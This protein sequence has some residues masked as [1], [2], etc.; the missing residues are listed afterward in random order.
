MPSS[1]AEFSSDGPWLKK[2]PRSKA[3]HVRMPPG[4]NWHAGSRF[5]SYEI[6]AAIGTGGMGEVYRARDPKLNRDVAIK[7]LLPSVIADPN[8]IAR[9]RREAQVLA[10]LN[11]PNIA[12]IHGIEEDGGITALI[13]ELVEGEDLSQRI[14]RGPLPIDEALAIARQIAEA[15]EA[16]HDLGIIHRDLK[17]ANIK[18]RADGTVKVLDFGLAKASDPTAS[19]SADLM[20]SPTLSIHATQAGIILGTA[21]YMSPEQARGK[22]VDRRT[23]IWALGCVLFEMLTGN[24]P[25]AG[26]DATDTLVAVMSKEPRWTTLPASVPDAVRALLHLTL[27]KQPRDRLDSAA[28]FRLAIGEPLAALGSE[29][30]RAPHV[31]SRSQRLAVLAW[32][33]A[34]SF[35]IALL[36]STAYRSQ[37]SSANEVIRFAIEPASYIRDLNPSPGYSLAASPDGTKL[38]FIAL[39]GNVLRIYVR[40][41]RSEAVTQVAGTEGGYLPFWSPDGRRLGFF[42]GD[43]LYKLDLADGR[44]ILVSEARSPLGGTWNANQDILFA[45]YSGFYRVAADNGKAVKVEVKDPFSRAERGF[46]QFLPDNDHFLY[47]AGGPFDS[48]AIFV[49]SLT[50]PESKLVSNADSAG[51]YSA[52][53]FLLFTKGTAL[54][55]QSFDL[56]SLLTIGQPSRLVPDIASA[57]N[58][59][60]LGQGVPTFAVSGNLLAFVPAVGNASQQTWFARN[61][62]QLSVLPLPASGEFANPAISPDGLQVLF[63]RID[64]ETGN[65]DVWLIRSDGTS[66]TRLTFDAAEESDAVWSPDGRSI[67]FLSTRNQKYGLYRKSV[68]SQD[69]DELIKEFDGPVLPSSWS[70]DG[71]FIVYSTLESTPDVWALP[72]DGDRVPVPVR[73]SAFSEYGAQ[74]SP[75]SRW[76]AYASD[77]TGASEVYVQ[78]FPQGGARVRVSNSGGG[79][80]PRWRSDGK[81]LFY[82]HLTSKRVFAIG[83]RSDGT[84]VTAGPER[85]MLD[86]TLDGMSDARN[87]YAVAPDGQ[88]ALLRKSSVTARQPSISV[89]VNWATE[90]RHAGR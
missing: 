76:I 38:A 12:H 3:T 77:E 86:V 13:L 63:N 67:A 46:P 15:L 89:M 21:A 79:I 62:T 84:T 36:V 19:L 85:P 7:V 20:N 90:L 22:S 17:P 10:S 60:E 30:Y 45:S 64:P 72:L 26:E 59:A 6:V 27:Q 25:F 69:D 70:P 11:H 24:R 65:R 56:K 41:L 53:G 14:G 49:G 57:W 58:S 78:A 29:H 54:M 31:W 33:L 82:W 44:P 73:R 71:R 35:A 5:G 40:D 48:R 47:Y 88:R 23:D 52:A 39:S 2:R 37:S 28:A 42:S 74:V 51:Q 75:D 87:H 55:A 43:K 68:N 50:Q 1:P 9:F 8:R 18:V 83:I 16:A 34:A 4:M 66:P 80:H 32:S 81:E 61:G